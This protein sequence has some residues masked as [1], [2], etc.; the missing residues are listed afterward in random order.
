MKHRLNALCLALIKHYY[1]VNRVLICIFVLLLTQST[2]TWAQN[3][4]VDSLQRLLKTNLPDST[5]IDVFLKLA[6]SFNKDKARKVKFYEEALQG[7]SEIKDQKRLHQV[8]IDYSQ[9]LR[10]NSDQSDS[11]EHIYKRGLKSLTIPKYLLSIYYMQGEFYFG[12]GK[13]EAAKNSINKGIELAEKNNFSWDVARGF[14][15][16]GNGQFYKLEYEKAFSLYAKADSVC[17]ASEKLRVSPIRAKIQ[18]YMG[19]AVRITH[20]Y[21]KAVEYYFKAKEIY[22]ELNDLSGVQ[23]VNLGLT[24]YYTNKGEYDKAEQLLTQAVTY[25]RDRGPQS[26]YTYAIISRGYFFLKQEMYDKALKDYQLYH[27][28]AFEGTNKLFQLNAL[29]YMSYLY[30]EMGKLKLASQFGEDGIKLSKEIGEVETRKKIYE[31]LVLIYTKDEATEKLNQTY[32]NYIA[33]RDELDSLGKDKEIFELEAKYQTE[34]KEQ[35]IALLTTQ[36]Q[37]AR[38]EKQNQLYLL[39]GIVLIVVIVAVFFFILYRNRQKTANKLKELDK[40][41]SH[42]FANVSHEFRTPLTLI[43]S[44][45]EKELSKPKLDPELKSELKT[46]NRNAD[47]LLALVDQLLDLSKLESGHMQLQVT[48]ANLLSD[49]RAIASAFEFLAEQKSIQYTLNI[50]TSNELCWY[51][52]D[53]V[54]KIAANLLSNAFKYTEEGGAVM[55]QVNITNGSLELS[56]KNTGEGIKEGKI[57][58]VLERFYQS[59]N[60]RDGAGIGLALVNE[61]ITL[62]KGQL[63]FSSTEN[64][65]TV[66]TV[67]LPVRRERFSREECAIIDSNVSKSRE[68]NLVQVISQSDRVPAFN[69]PEDANID[70][71][72]LLVIDDNSDIRTLIKSLFCED[73]QVIEAKNGRI[74]IEKAIQNIPDVIISDVMMPEVDGVELSATLKQDERTSHIPIILLTAKAGDV[75]KMIG[76]ETGADDYV[77]KPFRN[78]ILKVRVKKLV[79]LREQL[80]KRYSH[81][82]ILKPKEVAVTT[83]DEK[84]MQRVQEL[85]DEKIT[86]S[87]FNAQVFSEEIGMSRMQ[88]HRKLKALIGQTTSEFIRSQ[89]L[90]LAAQMLKKE[91]INMSEVGY[92]VGFNDPSYFS[93]CFKE[94]F[95]KSP[96]EYA[97]LHFK[98]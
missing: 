96:S 54:E 24:Q 17:D 76:L 26:S 34:K 31:Q 97:E 75:N 44:P 14:V 22:Q 50:P 2:L 74:G 80:R 46:I 10:E 64:G 78:E 69:E 37:L 98:A 49:I 94:Y 1:S 67:Q 12:Q 36:N 87:D 52:Q 72:I 40:L 71:P 82:L 29:N 38:Q 60:S 41:K 45:V 25:Y 53:V 62:H 91:G 7:A 58:K 84:F 16:L 42:F 21:D 43:K 81:E 68:G 66:F 3:N 93:K 32:K 63:S 86:D 9:W 83:T 89:R 20:G 92:A 95:G 6:N 27:D 33:L 65:W 70:N 73:Y 59:D 48:R 47:R 85:L 39:L 23:E 57:K 5:R 15:V 77:I 19:Y 30:L 55:I 13:D 51:D 11:I 8:I 35:E 56:V 4:S 79:E 88:L 90:Q 61:L 28:I 18:N